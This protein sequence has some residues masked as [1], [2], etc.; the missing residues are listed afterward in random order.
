MRFLDANIFIYAYYKPKRSLTQKE[1]KMKTQAKKIIRNISEAKEEVT[2]TVIHI[3]EAVNIL[4]HGMPLQTLT[5]TILGLFMLENVK[6]LGVNKQLYFA[7]T[8]LAQDLRLDPNN[9]LIIQ[10]MN[11]TNIKEVYS[12]DKDLEK[13]EGITRL[14]KY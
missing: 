12:F 8:E 9:S 4:K 3:A 7:A 2:T 11:L 14:P 13:I 10:T 5:N 6:I 1:Q